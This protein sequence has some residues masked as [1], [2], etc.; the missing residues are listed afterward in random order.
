MFDGTKDVTI[1]YGP[2]NKIPMHKLI[3]AYNTKEK[4]YYNL[5]CHYPQENPRYPLSAILNN[6]A[7]R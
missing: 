4:V 3:R 6:T 2:R 5:S 7:N 1:K